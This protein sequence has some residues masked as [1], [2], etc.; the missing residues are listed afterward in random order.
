MWLFGLSIFSS[1]FL[2]FVVQPL[3]ARYVLPWF[4]GGSGVW[5]VCLLFF[6]TMLVGGYAYAHVLT[7]RCRPRAQAIVHGALLVLALAFLPIV[8]S[9]RWAVASADEPTWRILGLL[10]ATLGVPYLA[11]S[12]TGPLLQ[13]WLTLSRS[14][15]TPYRLYALSNAGSLLGLLAYPFAIEPWWPRSTQVWTWSAGFVIFAAL[16]AACAWHAARGGSTEATHETAEEKCAKSPSMRERAAW[17]AL[18][19]TATALLAAMTNRLTM[20]V[21]P[22]PFLWVLPL[23]VYL[24]SLVICF[25]RPRW[26]V[27]AIFGALL[28]LAVGT[29]A[30]LLYADATMS[31]KVQLVAYPAVLFVACMVCHGEVYRLRPSAERLT[32]F[33]LALATGG[34]LGTFF[35]AVVA[36]RIFDDYHELPLALGATVFFFGMFS[37]RSRRGGWRWGALVAGAAVAALLLLVSGRQRGNVVATARNFHGVLRLVEHDRSDPERRHW[38]LRHG[39]TAHGAQ[40]IAAERARWPTMYYGESGGAGVVLSSIK[41]MPGRN[42][43][44]V[45]L[46]AGTLVAYGRVKDHFTCYELNPA[47]IRFAQKP[48]AFL[49]NT[50]PEVEIVAG[51]ARLALQ[52]EAAAGKL[53]RFDLLA[54]DAFSSDSIPTH[55]LTAEAMEIYLRHLKPDGI[56][57]V[58]LSNRYLDLRGV[59]VGL[60]RQFGMDFVI[61]EDAPKTEF[62]WLSSSVWCLLTRDRTIFSR[63]LPSDAAQRKALEDGYHPVVWTDDHASVWRVLR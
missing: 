57:A 13:R 10:A 9:A 1:A 38:E 8:P 61:V 49:K 6:Q 44:L 12:A 53:R 28:A 20:D 60:A 63:W 37:R 52:A 50:A 54:L 25:D 56:I 48:F 47:V 17:I 51:D 62:Y 7:T 35:V 23:G 24:L 46:G 33:Y 16:G 42:V 18:P 19:A 11:L 15:P 34:A 26:Y 58:H 4:G 14:D 41:Y 27:R 39:A 22:I 3:I 55:L 21:A 40:F 29:M 30:V 5:T 45:G 43:G 36:P 59:T 31:L 32:G 2:L